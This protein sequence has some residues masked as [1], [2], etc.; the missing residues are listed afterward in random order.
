MKLQTRS[1]PCYIKKHIPNI[2]LTLT[3]L[4]SVSFHPLLPPPEPG[5]KDSLSDPSRR[6]SRAGSLTDQTL[7]SLFIRNQTNGP[8]CCAKAVSSAPPS[9][10][11]KHSP[12]GLEQLPDSGPGAVYPSTATQPH[13]MA[14]TLS[15][16]SPAGALLVTKP[17]WWS[18]IHGQG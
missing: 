14:L 8:H 3:F 16:L 2:F 6:G 15:P 9:P 10:A 12:Q 1:H 4:L 13:L 18:R 7:T 17:A 5:D 11:P